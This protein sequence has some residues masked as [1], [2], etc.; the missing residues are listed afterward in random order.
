MKIVFL[1]NYY[2][3]HQA[4]FS[5]EMFKLIGDSY[6]FIETKEIEAE[7]KAMGWEIKQYPCFV[8]RSHRSIEV[9]E[10]CKQDIIN[11][12]VVII[13]SAP[14]SFIKERIKKG[15]LI[16]RYSER[17]LKNG[18]ELIKYPLRWIR[19]N[20]RNPKNKP[21]Y[22]LCAS[23][24]TSFD[25]AKFGLFKGRCYKWG[26][27]PKLI[28][29]NNVESV[30]NAKHSA[31]LLWVSRLIELKHPEV[32]LIIAKKLKEAGYIFSLTLVGIGPMEEMVRGFINNN[33]LDDCVKL[34]GTMSPEEVRFQMEQSE[35]FLFTS[36][37]HEGWGA[38][39][40]ESMNSACAIVAN[41]T[42]GSVPFLIKDGE[43]GLI[44]Q[45]GNID[46]LYEK[47]RYLLED[48]MEHKRLGRNA[49]FSIVESWNEEV[50]TKRLLQLFDDIK[51]NG[52]SSRYSDGPCSKA[53]IIIKSR[54]A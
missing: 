15:K 21:I 23:A 11:A 53:E 47:V 42:I 1:S 34:L 41:S 7:R 9:M 49:Y 36:D 4:P 33:N 52:M 16:F 18:I 10:Q 29:Y 2:N 45:D 6:I 39:L 31:S 32:P 26:Y 3:H 43:N 40:N 5:E 12:D 38:V 30:L 46:E 14:E 13:G 44:Y 22:M 35:V 50:A 27:F 24:Y 54:H 20:K 17:P 19:W 28:K 25:Y 48:S 8:K 37:K 51:R